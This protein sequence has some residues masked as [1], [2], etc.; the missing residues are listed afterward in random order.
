MTKP[1]NALFKL[2]GGPYNPPA[3][4]VGDRTACLYRGTEV[5]ITSWTAARVPWPRCRGLG[6]RGGSGLLINDELLRAIRAESA[7]ALKYWFGV[8][9]RAVW[10][11]RKAF[12]I[13]QWGT[14]GSR[15]LLQLSSQA[16]ANKVRGRKV[17]A[18]VLRK[19]VQTRRLRDAE[20]L[21]GKRLDQRTGI[22]ARHRV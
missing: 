9:T 13:E 17:P 22:S 3:L 18:A 6:V 14:D 5:V 4:R 12:G 7:E 10:S 1:T 19:R 8:G 11:W 2:L 15:R 20:P 16:G 21:G